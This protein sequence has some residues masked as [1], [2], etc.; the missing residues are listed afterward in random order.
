M[1]NVLVLYTFT[2]VAQPVVVVTEHLAPFQIVGPDGSITGLNTDRVRSA[3]DQA[4]IPYT[5]YSNEWTVSYQ[6]AL[7][8]RDVCIYSLAR[9][10][11]R[12]DMFAWIGELS[13]MNAFFYSNPDS[14]IELSRFDDAKRF[15]VAAMENDV[16]LT[17]LKSK[18]FIENQNLY[19]VKNYSSLLQLLD[20]RSDIIDLILLSDD[21][22]AY[23]QSGQKNPAKFRKHDNFIAM[24]I[25]FNLA[26]N[27]NTKPMLIDKLSQA[28]TVVVE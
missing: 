11:E 19:T 28:L 18:G 20:K 17:Y 12:E 3:F 2:T 21:L 23:R 1:F 10:P 15:R 4:N 22:L 24:K 25:D 16:S 14:D 9:I 13:S 6:Q 7:K 8:N 26:C 27:V 5:L